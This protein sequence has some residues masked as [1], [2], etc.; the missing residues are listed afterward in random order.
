MLT[1][2]GNVSK[3]KMSEL[4]ITTLEI[5]KT[6]PLCKIAKCSNLCSKKRKAIHIRNYLNDYDTLNKKSF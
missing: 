1:S 4:K 3:T 2:I 5:L 6:C